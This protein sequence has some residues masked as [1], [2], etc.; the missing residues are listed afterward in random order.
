RWLKK[1][2]KSDY[3]EHRQHYCQDKIS[4]HHYLSQ[5]EHK[6]ENMKSANS[7]S[8]TPTLGNRIKTTGAKGPAFENTSYTQESPF[9]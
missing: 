9:K 7:F 6:V 5:L 3:N 1:I 4:V 2:L 8:P